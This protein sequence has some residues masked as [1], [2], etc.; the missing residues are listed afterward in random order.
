M[1]KK[2]RNSKIH[3]KKVDTVKEEKIDNNDLKKE[4][5]EK[6]L[7]SKKVYL[8]YTCRLVLS[9]IVFVIAFS[10]CLYL[11]TNSFKF[12][13]PEKIKYTDTQGIDYKVYLKPNNF[14]EEK[15]LGKNMMY[16]ANLI[17]KINIDFN[18]K[19]NIEKKSTIDFNYKIIGDLIISNTSTNA[20]YFE[21]EY[22][23]FESEQF[24]MTDS[25][26]YI[27]DKEIEVNYNKYNDLANSFRTN[28]GV[29][30]NSYLKVYLQVNKDGKKYNIDISNNSE[31]GITI[32]LSENS[33]QIKFDS[34]DL[35]KTNEIII[36][37]AW[38]F[39]PHIF[40][41]EII[42]FL[43]AA[44]FLVKIIKLVT[45]TM[46]PKSPY[47]KFI[48]DVLVTY[49]R[50]IGQTKTGID[51]KKYHVIEME[52]FSELLDI[53]DNLQ[54]PIMYYNIVKHQKCYFYIK[55]NKD[56]YLFKLK[57]VDMEVNSEKNK[58]I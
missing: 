7:I 54:I 23:L 29:N 57:A 26:E 17:D 58:W 53:H 28:Y 44:F 52:S 34:S 3:N 20:P 45:S 16:V 15:Y 43:I 36:K 25:T 51:F 46:K 6:E 19:F 14:Y 49:D 11:A 40:T 5:K 30:T 12:K 8:S 56:V 55:N 22:T 41:F 42:T 50:I 48:D 18:Y 32:P 13:H 35:T 38:V 33:V 24:T 1:D 37:Q 31:N 2:I 10:S 21:K 9:L 27:I 47:D 39:Q 4:T